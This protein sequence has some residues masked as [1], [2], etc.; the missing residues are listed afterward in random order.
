MSAT[1]ERF[2]DFC[3]IGMKNETD[4]FAGALAAERNIAFFDTFCYNNNGRCS[5][6]CHRTLWHFGLRRCFEAVDEA[7]YVG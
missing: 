3:R 2:A 6:K 1:A 7:V 4:S 5:K